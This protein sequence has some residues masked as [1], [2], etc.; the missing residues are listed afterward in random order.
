MSRKTVKNWNLEHDLTALLD[1]LCAEL[2]AASDQEVEAW[3]R[4]GGAD[5]DA[6]A[7]AVRR[8]VATAA[9]DEPDPPPVAP[10]AATRRMAQ[11]I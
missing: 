9:S 4:E 2:L 7:G 3:L 11:L 6:A 5:A 1:G 10:P 8:L